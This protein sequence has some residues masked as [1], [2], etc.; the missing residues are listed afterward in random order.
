MISAVLY[1][2]L[3]LMYEYPAGATIT[4]ALLIVVLSYVIGDLGVLAMTN[5][6]VATLADIGLCTLKIWLL[7]PLIVGISIPFLTALLASLVIGAGEWFFH[8]YME[9]S[10]LPRKESV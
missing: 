8:K 4:L 5:N 2:V 3:T 6:T 7:G 1:V 9:N 10:V